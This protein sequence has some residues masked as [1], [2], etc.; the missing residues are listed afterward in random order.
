M[1]ESVSKIKVVEI[2]ADADLSGGPIHVLNLLRNLD[3]GKFDP[4]LICPSGHLVEEAKNIRDLKIETIEMTSRFDMV[5]VYQIFRTLQ[6]IQAAANPFGKM[7][8]HVHGVRAGFLARLF[9]L[10][11]AKYIYTEHS[12]DQNYHLASFGR[13]WLQ[14]LVLKYL[15]FKTDTVIAVSSSVKSYLVSSHLSLKDRTILVPNGFDKESFGLAKIPIKKIKM[16]NEAPVV[17][18]IGNLNLQKGQSYLIESMKYIVKKYPLATL[19]IIGEGEQREKLEKQIED[20]RLVKN[21][22]LLG[23]K[24]N[25]V[26]YLKNWDVFVLPS[27]AETFGIS[28]LEAMAVG[29]PVVASKTGGIVDIVKQRKNG[30]LI[31][32]KNSKAIAEAVIAIISDPIKAA[33]YKREAK[34]TLE[35]Y[36]WDK[37]IKEIEAIYE[38]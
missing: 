6:K 23:R 11:T 29:I 3:K 22:T 4:Y 7:I 5:A 10:S 15:N 25:V 33:S 16:C 26:N 18:T 31:E 1:K 35:K 37:I 9:K 14:K 36:R 17:G 38:G 27:I 21:I 19:E 8:V 2:I 24:S 30:L 34:N 20:L 13:E 28:I 12:L 32:P